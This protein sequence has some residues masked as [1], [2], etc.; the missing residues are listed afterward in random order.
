[1]NLEGGHD[2]NAYRGRAHRHCVIDV[3]PVNNNKFT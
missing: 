2:D 3:R 1:M